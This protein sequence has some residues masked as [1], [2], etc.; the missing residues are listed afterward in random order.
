MKGFVAAFFAI[1]SLGIAL[2]LPAGTPS[3]EAAYLLTADRSLQGHHPYTT[4]QAPLDSWF[5]F[6]YQLF[7][8]KAAY[9]L[10]LWK[11]MG[12]I[13]LGWFY[14][15]SRPLPSPLLVH[16]VI[17]IG[18]IGL[19]LYKPWQSILEVG[20]PLLWVLL[21]LNRDHSSSFLRGI[22]SGIGIGFF[23]IAILSVGWIV[24][25]RIEE[26]AFHRLLLWF[27]GLLWSACGWAAGLRLLRLFPEYL[28]YYWLA[29]WNEA[30]WG[31]ILLWLLQAT[32]VLLLLT[33]GSRYVHQPYAQ[34]RAYRDRFWA[35]ILSIFMPSAPALWLSLVT[36]LSD[37][38]PRRYL[39]LLLVGVYGYT[40]FKAGSDRPDCIITLPSQSCFWGEPPCYVRLIPP[41]ACNWTVP[42]L[43]KKQLCRDNWADFYD[44]W[45]QPTLIIDAEGVWAEVSYYLPYQS[46]L[47]A[48]KDTTLFPLRLYQRR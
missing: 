27:G 8:E 21:L 14:W 13:F 4:L 10:R 42:L 35:A 16:D 9:G 11:A 23:P 6:L 28:S 45:G 25:R 36:E 3:L 46:L 20:V 47:Y 19:Y 24:Y 40:L 38:H 44:R 1:G 17:G 43:W 5:I 37:K 31:G 2:L 18:L 39:S 34:R 32:A 26:R 48:P 12:G 30:A 7:G 33:Q 41:Y 29:V 15:V 22:L